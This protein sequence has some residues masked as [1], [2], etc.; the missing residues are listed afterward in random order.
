M[1]INNIKVVILAGGYGIRL[2]S[3]VSEVPK[4]MAPIQGKPFLEYQ[5]DY[6]KKLGFRNIIL[7][8]SYLK[9]QIIDYF[10]DGS[11]FGL[12]IEY[13][14]EEEPLGTGGALKNIEDI[15]SE[16]FFVVNGDTYP[17]FDILELV[18]FYYIKKLSGCLGVIMV[19]V[20][21]NSEDK[22]TVKLGKDGKIITFN[23][24]KIR[25][26]VDSFVN[27]GVYFLNRNIFSQ[28]IWE[29]KC[30]LEK[31]IFPRLIS[32]ELIF[33]MK[34]N[35]SFIDIG[36][37]EVYKSLVESQFAFSDLLQELSS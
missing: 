8:V 24:K 37:L 27:A 1:D 20:H 9:E 25:N 13:G 35:E 2:R 34:T 26:R 22:G 32:K 28:N 7:C 23:E 30:S 21:R 14:I 36:T 6:L 12:K 18:K 31:D 4:P 11:K 19:S 17:L 5:I 29:K 15:V 10:K 16:L 3:V 33:G